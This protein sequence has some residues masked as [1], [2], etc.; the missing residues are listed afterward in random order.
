[1]EVVTEEVEMSALKAAV[2]ALIQ[3]AADMDRVAVALTE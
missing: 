1:V 2:V 3:I